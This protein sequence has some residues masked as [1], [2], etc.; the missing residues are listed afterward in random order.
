[1]WQLMAEVGYDLGL[2][3]EAVLRPKLGLGMASV[4]IEACMDVM[5][6]V[7]CGGD[8]ESK[9]AIAPGAQFLYDV[10]PVFLSAE[11]RHNHV[12]TEGNADGFLVGAGAGAAF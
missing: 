9:F 4:K 12:F 7:S 6:V 11:A 8:S 1:M 10:G 3:P 5:G 2:G